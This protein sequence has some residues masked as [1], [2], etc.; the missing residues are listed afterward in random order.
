MKI[1]FRCQGLDYCF[2]QVMIFAVCVKF[3]KFSGYHSR[4]KNEPLNVAKSQGV[5]FF[6]EDFYNAR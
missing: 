1:Q 2:Q 6:C 4:L 5:N 3:Q